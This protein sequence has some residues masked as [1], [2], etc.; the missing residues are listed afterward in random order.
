MTKVNHWQHRA[1]ECGE[2]RLK[3][4]EGDHYYE[5][6]FSLLDVRLHLGAGCWPCSCTSLS[7][8]LI[9]SSETL[10]SSLTQIVTADSTAEMPENHSSLNI[11]TLMHKHTHQ[12]VCASRDVFRTCWQSS[13][14]ITFSWPEFRH[15]LLRLF[16]LFPTVNAHTHLAKSA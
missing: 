9:H 16:H 3:E 6:C 7:L 13:S 12:P 5:R 11:P 2:K 8:I 1:R 14:N 15:S 10:L 4:R